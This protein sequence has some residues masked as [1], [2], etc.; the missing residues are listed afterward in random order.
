MR[1]LRFSPTLCWWVCFPTHKKIFNGKKNL[2]KEKEKERLKQTTI[3]LLKVKGHLSCALLFSLFSLWLSFFSSL[4]SSVDSGVLRICLIC[5][6][7]SR[8]FLWV[9]GN[10][11]FW[12]SI[13]YFLWGFLVELLQ[14][15]IWEIFNLFIEVNPCVIFIWCDLILSFSW[16]P[17]FPLFTFKICLSGHCWC[18]LFWGYL[19]IESCSSR[20]IGFML[21]VWREGL[22]ENL[23][24]LFVL[25]RFDRVVL[26]WVLIVFRFCRWKKRR[27]LRI[28]WHQLLLL[29]KGGFKKLVTMLVAYALRI[30]V[31]VI[32]LRYND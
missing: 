24:T 25:F 32:L 5:S 31:K 26:V 30:F 16:M 10:F 20:W 14:P 2:K 7:S 29:W 19:E 27:I 1:L 11:L 15:I 17:F 9:W 3:P 6:P 22:I 12:S 28:A 4:S 8:D 18:S 21:F 23:W 13:W